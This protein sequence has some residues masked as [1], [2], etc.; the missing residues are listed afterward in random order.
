[1]RQTL[2]LAARGRQ[3]GTRR[4][5]RPPTTVAGRRHGGGRLSAARVADR[6]RRPAC[7]ARQGRQDD[8]RRRGPRAGVSRGHPLPHF[9]G[10]RTRCWPPWS[11][12]EVAGSSRGGCDGGGPRSRGRAGRRPDRGRTGCS[13]ATMPPL[14]ARPRARAWSCRTWP[15]SRWTGSAVGRG[16]PSPHRSSAAGWS[17]TEAARAAEWAARIVRVRTCARPPRRRP[18]PTRARPAPGRR[19]VLPGRPGCGTGRVR[20]DATSTSG[21]PTGPSRTT[22]R[23]RAMTT[24]DDSR[25][26]RCAATLELIGRDDVNDLEA[27]SP[28]SGDEEPD[29]RHRVDDHARPSSPGTTTRAGARSST[30]ST[31]RP[32][33][34]SGTAATDLPWDTEVDQEARGHGRTP[35]PTGDADA[36]GR[37]RPV[38]GTALEK[39][40]DKEWLQF[41]VENQN[42]TLS[43]VHARRA[44]RAAVHGQDRRDRAVDRRQV[45][46]RHP[47]RRRGPPRRG[48]HPVPGREAL[49]PLPDERPPRAAARRHHRRLAAGT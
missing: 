43:P 46:R 17:P 2:H 15:S 8:G 1:M 44:G 12:T 29:G 24:D 5:R 38:G 26:P 6:G 35:R 41:G 32:R 25:G 30:S 14:P 4:R 33:R 22:R 49:G 16:E 18:D 13:S 3:L 48:L 47:G 34:P 21:R 23:A 45:L 7:L 40:G 42:W 28:W 20:V 31:R 39:W 37:R 10:G 27:S 36:V 9:P 11:T 19:F